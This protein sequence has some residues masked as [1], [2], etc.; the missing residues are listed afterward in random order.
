MPLVSMKTILKNAQKGKYAVG[1]FESWNLESTQ[2]IAE[3]AQEMSSPVIIG[4]NGGILTS[5][6]RILKP[7]NLD[8]FAAIGRVA[9]REASVPVG[10][11]LNEIPDLET[12]KRAVSLGFIGIMFEDELND[13]EKSI[14]STKKAV[15]LAHAA[16]VWVESRVGNLP[17]ARKGLLSRQ[18]DDNLLTRA[19]EAQ[20]FVKET[21]VDAIAVS[22]GNVEVLMEG[23][24]A[25]DFGRLKKIHSLIN[26]P[27][28]LHG[29]SGLPDESVKRI[30]ELGVYKINFGARLNQAFLEGMDKTR[31]SSKK[32]VSPKYLLGSGLKEDLFA[33]GR[34]QMKE[35]VKEKM[36]VYGSAWQCE[37]HY[38]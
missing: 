28:V 16:G 4:F 22:V 17:V 27:L 8:Y 35:L 37:K 9:A 3:A 23:K 38:E 30:I 18:D 26:I 10:L 13:F 19:E 21:G 12:V 11:I 24:P 25:I 14:V 31:K 2:A 6:E 7:E 29:G 32:Y 34:L 36:K 20:R 15:N 5:Q 33:G 1:Y